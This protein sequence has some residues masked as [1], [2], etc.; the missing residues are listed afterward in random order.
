MSTT[1]FQLK[2]L[3]K[4]C[5]SD[6]NECREYLFSKHLGIHNVHYCTKNQ[7][8]ICAMYLVDKTM[9]YRENIVKIPYVV[10]LA[11]TKEYRKQG[12][13]QRLL[14]TVLSSLD[15]PFVMLYSEV[16]GF[17]E[18]MDFSFISKDNICHKGLSTQRTNNPE[19]LH[20]LYQDKCRSKDF[21]I[22]LTEED[23]ME[24]IK[25]IELDGGEFCILKDGDNV[26][27]YTSGEE[28]IL[29]NEEG[30]EN[31]VMGRICS[32][33]KAFMLTKNTIPIKLKLTDSLIKKHNICFTVERG[34]IK[35]CTDFDLTISI[36][37]LTAHFF[38]YQGRL[39][40]F[41]CQNIGFLSE[42]Y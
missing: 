26:M 1:L 35:P 27:G 23:F 4:E 20:K 2:A 42:R 28:T 37:E 6:S 39:K 10:A 7:K 41:F 29:V 16:E 18:K 21:Y 36:A 3:Y 33:E 15:V 31:G 14:S 32:I 19:L 30:V 9:K 11:T 5:F 22:T 13:A 12:Y 25:I 8:I 24:K 34:I 17:Y 40:E 38:G